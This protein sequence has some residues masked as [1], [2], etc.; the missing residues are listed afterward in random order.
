MAQSDSANNE[1]ANDSGC[2]NFSDRKSDHDSSNARS[3][4]PI[5][6]E[7]PKMKRSK[8]FIPQSNQPLNSGI[9]Y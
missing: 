4:S 5:S 9:A 8:V 2:E 7:E 3:I 1:S 6:D